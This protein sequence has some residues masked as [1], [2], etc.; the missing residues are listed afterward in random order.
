VNGRKLC[1]VHRGLGADNQASNWTA[2]HY[3]LP[4]IVHLMP[5]PAL[6][7]SGVAALF[8]HGQ[9]SRRAVDRDVLAEVQ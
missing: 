2:R 6:C 1:R 7:A 4:V 9:E 8:E 3:W 5:G